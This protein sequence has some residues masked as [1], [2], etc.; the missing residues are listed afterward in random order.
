MNSIFILTR[1][2]STQ[3]HGES[4]DYRALA[5]YK[6]FKTREEAERYKNDNFVYGVEV[7]ELK[8]A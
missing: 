2:V 8:P 3:G 7:T 4:W 5:D 1:E 6:F